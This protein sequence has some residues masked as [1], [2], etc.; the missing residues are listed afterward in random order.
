MSESTSP[1]VLV[2][3]DEPE[4]LLVISDVF[5]EYLPDVR[6]DTVT[7]GEE[8]LTRFEEHRSDVVVTDL[9]MPGMDGGALLQAL[10][11]KA[12]EL[13]VIVMTAHPTIDRAVSLLK[14]GAHDFIPKPFVNADLANRVRLALQHAGLR[15]EVLEARDRLAAIEGPVIFRG[16]PMEGIL[17]QLPVMAASAAPVL[18]TGESGT[19]KELVA[20]E[21]HR[22]SGRRSRHFTAVNCGAFTETLLESEL[23]GYRK[24]AFT[25]A[26]RDQPGIIR[27]TD[28]GTLFL[29]EIGE[30]S[31][32]LQI[33]LLRFL[34]EGE[35]RAVGDTAVHHVDVRV[36]AATNTDLQEACR[37]GRFREDLYYRL[38]VLPIHVP[39]LRQRRG[40]IPLLAQAFL[41]RYSKE[42]GRELRL[43]PEAA[44]SLL[45]YDWPGNVRELQNRIQRA[46]ILARGTE[47]EPNDLWE[48]VGQAP[49]VDP[50][51]LG[52]RDAREHV[53]RRFEESYVRR[54]MG[55]HR[56]NLA[57]AARDAGMDRKSFWRVMKRCDID[58]GG[59]REG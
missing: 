23:F 42:V 48:E 2:V 55:R 28:G 38:N 14:A 19:G 27:V 9:M 3:D 51:S 12:P 34:Q 54:L 53:L 45:E 58:P 30:T 16:E 40:D 29:D 59:F 1:H 13:P 43:S 57:A 56:G 15:R 44:R 8:A 49:P 37:Q 39:P 10:K 24:G 36:I 47:I 50:A 7:G 33:R 5:A 22:M 35:V 32:Q 6:L 21:L 25:G 31:P 4:I 46:A 26:H 11:E 52:Y 20:R 18:I 17:R 41:D